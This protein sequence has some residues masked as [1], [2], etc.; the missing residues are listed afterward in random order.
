MIVSLKLCLNLSL[1]VIFFYPYISSPTI[2]ALTSVSLS[3]K[4]PVLSKNKYSIYPKSSCTPWLK[5]FGC[6]FFYSRFE[7]IKFSSDS[8]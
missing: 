7:V 3:V 6:I 8:I 4:V 1:V 5:V 2:K